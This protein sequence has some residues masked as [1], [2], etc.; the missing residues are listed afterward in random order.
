MHNDPGNPLDSQDGVEV[1]HHDAPQKPEASLRAGYE[2]TDLNT[3]L[4]VY[5]LVALFFMMFGAIATI[6]IVI[7][8]FNESRPSLNTV[9]AS[10]LATKGVQ[11]P[12]EPHLQM[13]PVSDR[14]RIVSENDK[15]VNSYGI[16]SDESGTERVHIPVERAMALLAE[17]KGTYRQEPRDA[18]EEMVDP[19]AEDG[20]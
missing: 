3:R 13:D 4:I 10:A 6:L 8:G 20:L 1:L 17:G 7:R 9:P 11:V 18:V 2:V 15:K 14:V 5:F 12:D 19:F 16:I